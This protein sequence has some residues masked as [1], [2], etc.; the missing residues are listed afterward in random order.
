MASISSTILEK[1]SKEPPRVARQ[2]S[3][4]ET[5]HGIIVGPIPLIIQKTSFE[6]LFSQRT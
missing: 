5:S 6:R 2:D 4:H 3:I 1:S